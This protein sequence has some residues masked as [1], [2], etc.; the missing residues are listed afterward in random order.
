VPIG[1]EMLRRT[2]ITLLVCATTALTAAPAPASAAK[3]I[4]AK[5]AVA[6]CPAATTN[7]DRDS[8]GDAERSVLCLLNLERTSRGL[9]RLRSNE[10]L[11]DAAAGHSRDMVRRSYFSHVSLGGSTMG[12]RIRETGYLG[13]ARSYSMGENLAWGTGSLASPLKIVEAWMRSPGHRRNILHAAF[14]EVGVGLAL[15]APGRDR[16]ATYTTNF[17]ARR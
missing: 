15:G 6:A 17:G 3:R 14:E 10:R 1:P 9:D 4:S 7:P 16:G 11:A 5:A 2:G 13:R 8:A 12:E